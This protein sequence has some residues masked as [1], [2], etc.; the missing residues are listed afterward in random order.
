MKPLEAGS[1]K[2]EAFLSQP[3]LFQCV[4]DRLRWRGIGRLWRVAAVVDVLDPDL[5]R[6]ERV[7]GHPPGPGEELDARCELG[8]LIPAVGDQVE[9]LGLASR[10]CA[11]EVFLASLNHRRVQPAE[12]L[13][14]DAFQLG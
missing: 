14:V 6:V 5:A 3:A 13:R 8:S 12:A 1:W 2:L 11:D 10:R 9:E 7:D 4:L